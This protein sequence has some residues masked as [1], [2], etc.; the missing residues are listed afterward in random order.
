MC[1]VSNLVVLFNNMFL[2]TLSQAC[3]VLWPRIDQ[4]TCLKAIVSANLVPIVIEN[5]LEDDE[6]RTDF[7][8]L[9]SK[10]EELGPSK[11]VCVASTTSCFAPRGMDRMVQIAELCHTAG[12]PHVVNNAYGVQAAQICR[13]F[14]LP[15]TFIVAELE[16]LLLFGLQLVASFIVR[17]PLQ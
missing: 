2:M 6:L 15:Y 9:Q 11:I 10:I 7:V 17:L 1:K 14:N 4:K 8:G 5:L 16:P 13:Y 3:Y 12:I